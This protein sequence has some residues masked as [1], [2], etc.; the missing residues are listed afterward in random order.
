MRRKKGKMI[1]KGLR[2]A[3]RVPKFVILALIVL[4]ALLGFQVAWVLD[5]IV[6]AARVVSLS[7]IPGVTAA[8]DNAFQFVIQKFE[9]YGGLYDLY[10]SLRDGLLGVNVHF[11]DNSLIT[12]V[13]FLLICSCSVFV[14]RLWCRMLCPLGAWYAINAAPALLERRVGHCTSCGNCVR[15]CRMG[16]I[17]TGQDYQKGECVLCMDCVYDCPEKGTSF[18]WRSRA[19]AQPAARSEKGLTRGQFLWLFL[20]GI[21]LWAAKPARAFTGN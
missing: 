9:L 17:E 3:I 2:R 20:S 13:A 16:A 5:P 8:L 7:V 18:T 10:R 1:G 14:L 15:R 4:L 11:F 6:T 19:S 21:F 12:L